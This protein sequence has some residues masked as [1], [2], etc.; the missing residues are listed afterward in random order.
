MKHAGATGK[1]VVLVLAV[2]V[3]VWFYTDLASVPTTGSLFEKLILTTPVVLAIRVAVIFVAL[4]IIGLVISVFWKQIGIIKIGASGIEFGKVV[5]EISNKTQA[6]LAAKEA[7]N[8]ELEAEVETL[9]Q[10][11]KAWQEL[12]KVTNPKHKRQKS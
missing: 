1:S 4:G 6:E 10:E 3:I 2:A 9:K 11:I 7:R 12:T 5:D 8:R